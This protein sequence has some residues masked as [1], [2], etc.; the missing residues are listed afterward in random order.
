MERHTGVNRSSAWKEEEEEAA[1]TT[2]TTASIKRCMKIS[3]IVP[4]INF[5]NI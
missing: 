4:W 5:Q 3:F 2:T 1:A